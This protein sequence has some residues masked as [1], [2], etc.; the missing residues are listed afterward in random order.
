MRIGAAFP[1]KYLKA[2]DLQGVEVT[3]FIDHVAMEDINKGEMKPVIY[4][5]G[6]KKGVVLNKT[7]SR[8]IEAAYGDETDEWSGQPIILYEAEVDF[9]GDTVQAIRVKIPPL[10]QRKQLTERRGTSSQSG[11]SNQG[12]GDAPPPASEHDYDEEIPF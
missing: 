3:V 1:S 4:F 7:N 11:T 2:S 10:S 5:R 9:Q 6:K 12:D 8:K